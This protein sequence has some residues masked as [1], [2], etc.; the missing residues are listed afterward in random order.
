MAGAGGDL[1]EAALLQQPQVTGG[2]QA[3]ESDA[4]G[5][6]E[7]LQHGGGGRRLAGAACRRQRP[8]DDAHRLHL[9]PCRTKRR[10]LVSGRQAGGRTRQATHAAA[11]PKPPFCL[12]CVHLVGWPP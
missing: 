9:V 4:A 7:A 8:G 6:A 11:D 5:Q 1:V 2:A 3:E 12:S 10:G